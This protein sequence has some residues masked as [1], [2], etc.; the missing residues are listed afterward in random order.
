MKAVAAL[1]Y[2]EGYPLL[3]LVGDTD[4]RAPN[5]LLCIIPSQ[6]PT[7]PLPAPPPVTPLVTNV[8]KPVI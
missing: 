7:T 6:P 8:D 4:N 1:H 2:M 3:S 5:H